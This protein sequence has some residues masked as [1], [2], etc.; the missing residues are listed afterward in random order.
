MPYE[1]RSIEEA[2]P[3]LDEIF[4]DIEAIFKESHPET[5]ILTILKEKT[6]KIPTGQ[7]RGLVI[8]EYQL[9]IAAAWV[10]NVGIHYGNVV[11]HHL[12]EGCDEFLVDEM[13]RE[14]Y[15]ENILVE[16]IQFQ[17]DFRYHDL[18]LD[19]GY[20]QNT[21]QRMALDF[22]D[23]PDLISEFP[24]SIR[25]EP[26]AYPDAEKSSHMS[27][28]AHQVS[29]DQP[30][31]PDL[32]TLD[33]RQELED[34]V[35]QHKFGPVIREATLKI[36]NNDEWVGIMIVIEIPCWG[37]PNLPW[38]FDVSVHPD[39]MGKGYGK[40]IFQKSVAELKKLGHAM[41][42]LAVTSNNE[43]AVNLYKK[44]GF[45]LVEEFQ[46]YIRPAPSD[47]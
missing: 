12:K 29:Q 42:G 30:H 22:K 10:E 37:F 28:L 13:D 5:T 38:V 3:W 19:R 2:I 16:L 43:S 33:K 9:P 39:F 26:L 7:I 6:Q 18:L 14:G 15:L 45:F 21:R 8:F 36:F 31:S 25:F 40:M 47:H 27:F 34:Q 24:K 41:V 1:V 17:P 20:I 44:S 35:L 32:K 46:E 4:Y 23:C 11:F